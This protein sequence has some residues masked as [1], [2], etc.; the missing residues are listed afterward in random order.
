MKRDDAAADP[1]GELRRSAAWWRARFE[2]AQAERTLRAR[3]LVQAE[4]KL[5]AARAELASV[6]A[7]V[8]WME[9]LL[10]CPSCGSDGGAG[11]LPPQPARPAGAAASPDDGVAKGTHPGAL[12]PVVGAETAPLESRV[13]LVRAVMESTHSAAVAS[14]LPA[15]AP[16]GPARF[17]EDDT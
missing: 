16:F 9:R 4:R 5:A 11:G 1:C 3:Q 8:A 10:T 6:R 12:L 7:Q 2:R 17:A 14:G 15:F 13:A